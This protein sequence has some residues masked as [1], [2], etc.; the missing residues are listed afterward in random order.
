MSIN[1]I[2]ILMYHRHR[3]LDSQVILRLFTHFQSK[4]HS[5]LGIVFPT[6][7]YILCR[8]LIIL[9]VELLPRAV[10]KLGLDRYTS[11]IIIAE[12]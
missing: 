6:Q 1:I 4:L 7:L 11:K 9:Y 3:L 12:Y 2:F 8:V 10:T 5:K